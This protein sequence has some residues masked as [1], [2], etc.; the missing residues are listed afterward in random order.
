MDLRLIGYWGSQGDTKYPDPASS[1]D[2]DWDADERD[3]VRTYLEQGL[4]VRLYMGYSTCRLCG[5]AQNGCLELTDGK[6]AWPEG[7]AHYVGE[8][9]VRLPQEFIEHVRLMQ[10][11]LDAA[12][13]DAAW[14]L[15]QPR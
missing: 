1:V 8:H 12:S 4:V 9:S 2:L 13:V 7:L 6:F 11:E 3:A 15:S 5:F 14:W 10:D